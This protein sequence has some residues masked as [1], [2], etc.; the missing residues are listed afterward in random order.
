[1]TSPDRL[2]SKLVTAFTI[3]ICSSEPTRRFGVRRPDGGRRTWQLLSARSI[4]LAIPPLPFGLR[5][6]FD[7]APR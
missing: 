3:L 6:S 4:A 2:R 5:L 7:R 1:M